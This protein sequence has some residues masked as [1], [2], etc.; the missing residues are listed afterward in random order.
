MVLDLRCDIDGVMATAVAELNIVPAGVDAY[1]ITQRS[2]IRLEP[3]DYLANLLP[4]AL[5]DATYDKKTNY[6]GPTPGDAG[7]LIEHQ[8]RYAVAMMDEL[9]RRL[10]E[11]LPEGA[12][13]SEEYIRLRRAE[14]CRDK[15]IDNPRDATLLLCHSVIAGT[16]WLERSVYL[17]GVAGEQ[18]YPVAR[19]W[20][21]RKGAAYK[22]YAKAPV[23]QKHPGA[24]REEVS[25]Q[26]RKAL[27]QLGCGQR[28]GW[29][30]E[31]VIALLEEFITA[32]LPLLNT[33]DTHVMDVMDSSTQPSDLFVAL[34]PLILAMGGAPSGG[35]PTSREQVAQLRHAFDSI[36]LTGQYR[37]K[38]L[39]KG[40]TIRSLLDGLCDAE[41]PLEKH[42][43]I[44][45]YTLKPQF[46]R[47]SRALATGG[48]GA[49]RVAGD[50]RPKGEAEWG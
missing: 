41:G 36:V 43:S 40:L 26:G 6:I 25:C 38:G 35:R 42:P 12:V 1:R 16:R 29:T 4:K 20:K 46:I 19:W 21:K 28:P 13:T 47:A 23:T 2:T 30:S 3:L 8:Y 14:L 17:A 50:N 22:V 48:M 33:L 31:D 49:E 32:T 7:H 10:D 27:Q 5:P 9:C 34:S 37:A 39:K 24:L 11:D 45:L 18:G 44:C 15:P